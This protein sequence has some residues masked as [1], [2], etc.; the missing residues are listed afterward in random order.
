VS[1]R[2]WVIF[3]YA[4]I[5]FLS[6]STTED[7]EPPMAVPLVPITGSQ[8]T[9]RP[10]ELPA[11]APPAPTRA[12]IPVTLITGYLGAGKTTLVNFILTAKHGY[13]CA[14]LLNEIADSAD[15]ERALVR[16][17][18]VSPLGAPASI[19]QV[20]W[21]GSTQ[22]GSTRAGAADRRPV[23]T[24]TGRRRGAAGRL[25]GA[26]ERLHLLLLEDRHGQSA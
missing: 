12:P 8:A 22:S 15:I 11:R 25:G 5:L 6:M 4:D 19:G 2:L 17:P 1:A 13:R 21:A 20:Q 10:S 16:E 14:V 9:Q 18:E 24:H 26:R 23:P 3:C 7:D